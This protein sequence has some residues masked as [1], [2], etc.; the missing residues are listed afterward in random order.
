MGSGVLHFAIQSDIMAPLKWTT[1][2]D[3]LNV[4]QEFKIF[5]ANNAAKPVDRNYATAAKT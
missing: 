3:N 4:Y 1:A 2:D 5:N